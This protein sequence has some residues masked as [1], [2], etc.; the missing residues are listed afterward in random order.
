MFH[1]S[2]RSIVAGK[3][4]KTPQE[5]STPTDGQRPIDPTENI[6]DQPEIALRANFPR[7]VIPFACIT[8]VLIVIIV[9]LVARTDTDDTTP[10]PEPVTA[11]VTL[12]DI[13]DHQRI[14]SIL[15]DTGLAA[16][17]EPG[18]VVQLYA[19]DGGDIPSL[20]YVQVYQC[21]DDRIL[22]LVD[23]TQTAAIVRK[24]LSD[25]VL[26]ISHK[27]P[28]RAGVLL[29]L[30]ERINDPQITLTLQPDAKT[31]PGVELQLDFQAEIQPSEAPLP[32]IRW[33]SD[34]PDIVTVQDGVI[35]TSGVGSAV[36]TACCGD[37]EAS[38]TIQVEIPLEA[39]QFDRQ[40]AAVAVGETLQ[41]TALPLPQ[42]ATQF[43]VA[44]S[45]EDPAVATVSEDGTVTGVAPGTV[46]IT[47]SSGDI[48]AQCQVTVGY[49]A[50]VVQLDRE[51]ISLAIGQT[52][53][54]KPTIYPS[55]DL[56][57]TLAF[58]SSNPRVV[59]V[60]ADGTVTAL[61]VGKAYVTFRC[62]NATAKCLVVVTT[63]ELQP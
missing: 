54:L 48:S 35:R 25:R 34:N 3:R 41:L 58:E 13:G 21:A 38:C 20:R 39:I 17:A 52:Y 2:T 11:A 9:L 10:E 56:I 42:D 26:L 4:H 45:S 36:I 49:H 23:D 22:L 61:A 30:Q 32:E 57:D 47:A 50:E 19:I 6:P 55:A 46:L 28:D 8:L 15:A 16:L 1:R 40:N 5:A 63:T 60:S 43:S 62:G 29:E 31:A 24:T 59:K 7:R 33:E 44:W 37:A 53:T 27:N 18:D 12:P 14:V 51:S